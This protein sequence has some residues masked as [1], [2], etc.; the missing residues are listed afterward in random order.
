[1]QSPLLGEDKNIY[2]ICGYSLRLT[3]LQLALHLLMFQATKK[4]MKRPMTRTT[5]A[6]IVSPYLDARSKCVWTFAMEEG[7]GSF[8]TRV[9]QHKTTDVVVGMHPNAKE[10]F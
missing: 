5:E 1:M 4:P 9:I 8:Q 10:A 6:G 7:D 2:V 3:M